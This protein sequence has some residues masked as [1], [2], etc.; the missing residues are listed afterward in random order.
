MFLSVMWRK[1]AYNFLTKKEHF[2][3]DKGV[4]R[5]YF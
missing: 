3:L 4:D 5:T 1:V 2:F